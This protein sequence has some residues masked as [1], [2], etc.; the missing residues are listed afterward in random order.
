MERSICTACAALG[1]TLCL[2]AQAGQF[3]ENLR[4][5][6]PASNVSMSNEALP[7]EPSHAPTDYEGTARIELVSVGVNGSSSSDLPPGANTTLDAAN[8]IARYPRSRLLAIPLL[9]NVI[10]SGLSS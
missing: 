5:L 10:S 4:T 1:L 9:P 6:I 3:C 8:W 2:H 7:A